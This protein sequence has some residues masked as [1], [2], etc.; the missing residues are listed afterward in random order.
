MARRD[1]SYEIFTTSRTAKL[2]DLRAIGITQG[3][4]SYFGRWPRGRSFRCRSMPSLYLA[5]TRRSSPM[6]LRGRDGSRARRDVAPKK[7]MSNRKGNGRVDPTWS[8]LLARLRLLASDYGQH[9][10]SDASSIAPVSLILTRSRGQRDY[11]LIAATR[12][13]NSNSIGLRTYPGRR[14]VLCRSIS[15]LIDASCMNHLSM[16]TEIC[17]DVVH[18]ACRA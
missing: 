7:T 8:R 16:A 2:P 11:A 13:L 5:V 12:A 9:V 3:N 17:D 14:V 10:T 15:H 1:L 4:A 6:A 18:G